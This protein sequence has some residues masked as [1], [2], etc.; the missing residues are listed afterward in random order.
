MLELGDRPNGLSSR[1]QHHQS[2]FIKTAEDLYEAI[3]GAVPQ[4]KFG[5]ASNEASGACLIRS[6]GNDPTLPD[7]AIGSARALGAGHPFCAHPPECL[8]HQRAGSQAFDSPA[9]PDQP[10]GWV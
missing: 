8:C 3:V 6:E 5:L 1:R 2:H 7:A 9:S 10:E 4:A